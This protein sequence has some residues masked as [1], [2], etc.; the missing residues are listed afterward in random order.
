[1]ADQ[2]KHVHNDVITVSR[3]LAPRTSAARVI[4][5]RCRQK[6]DQLSGLCDFL[7][8][9]RPH[10]FVHVPG[11]GMVAL[12]EFSD[13]H[14]QAFYGLSLQ[15]CQQQYDAFRKRVSAQSARLRGLNIM[16][17]KCLVIHPGLGRV[18]LC[19]LDDHSLRVIENTSDEQLVHAYNRATG[20]SIKLPKRVAPSG[21]RRSRIRERVP[22]VTCNPPVTP[23]GIHDR[24]LAAV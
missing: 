12:E 3:A 6:T 4:S 10:D 14:E 19:E 18:Q 21:T 8:S 2:E 5:T 20:A 23:K 15:E 7:D 1:L 9:E 17:P 24:L 22:Q 11:F 16:T 13:K